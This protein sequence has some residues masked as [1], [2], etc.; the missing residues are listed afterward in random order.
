MVSM[1]DA[2]DIGE[3]RGRVNGL[4][5]FGRGSPLIH[6]EPVTVRFRHFFVGD[7]SQPETRHPVIG[8]LERAEYVAGDPADSDVIEVPGHAVQIDTHEF[9]FDV[10]AAARGV[11][12]DRFDVRG[13]GEV[14]VIA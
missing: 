13:E 11:R 14:V 12:D 10:I 1:H 4:V 8:C 6:I 7:T 2:F 3:V 9:D 5:N